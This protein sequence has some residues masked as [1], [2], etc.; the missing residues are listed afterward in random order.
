MDV[1][2]R[3]DRAGGAGG[4]LREP[5]SWAYPGSPRCRQGDAAVTN[6]AR[7]KSVI[8]GGVASGE[9]RVARENRFLL[10]TRHSPLATQQNVRRLQVAVN[11]AAVV[12]V[13]GWP[14]RASRPTRGLAIRERPAGQA[15]FQRQTLHQLHRKIEPAILLA[16]FVN[17]DVCGSWRRATAAA[18]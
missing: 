11:D 8:F 2:R 12:G 9:W 7:P 5:C 18:S 3:T 17:L 13:S 16:D 15:A 1:G 10:A 6:L 4:L 14:A